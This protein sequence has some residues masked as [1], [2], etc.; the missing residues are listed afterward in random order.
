MRLPMI[1]AVARAEIRSNRRMVLYWLYAIL[2]VLVGVATYAQFSFLHGSFSAEWWWKRCSSSRPSPD[3]AW[4]GLVPPEVSVE[5]NQNRE[6]LEATGGHGGAEDE[7]YARR[8]MGEIV[9]GS[10]LA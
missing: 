7:F 4:R 1:L 5:E 10:D 8:K 6:E 2:A 3:F 9:E